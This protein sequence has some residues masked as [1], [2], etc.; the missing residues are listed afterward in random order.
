M[1]VLLRPVHQLPDRLG[2]QGEKSRNVENDER[3][4]HLLKK[5]IIYFFNFFIFI[6]R[7]SNYSFAI[8]DEASFFF[9][10]ARR[11][12]QSTH[13]FDLCFLNGP[14]LAS[15]LSFQTQNFIKVASA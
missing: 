4:R 2:E 15:F 14:N 10:A 7:M 9:E 11:F 13:A 8:L 12:R 6:N 5:G 1:V 3:Q